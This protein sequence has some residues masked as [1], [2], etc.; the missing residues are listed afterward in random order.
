MT[1]WLWAPFTGDHHSHVAPF[2]GHHFGG[3]DVPLVRGETGCGALFSLLGILSLARLEL[4][5]LFKIF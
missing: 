1:C 2:P 3:A 4:L 5:T